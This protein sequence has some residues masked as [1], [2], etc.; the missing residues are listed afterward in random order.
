M[1]LATATTINSIT[2]GDARA[3]ILQPLIVRFMHVEALTR[4]RG[5]TWSEPFFRLTP[6][7][8]PH[9]RDHFLAWLSESDF[10]KLRSPIAQ[11]AKRWSADLAVP[12]SIPARGGNLVSRKRWTTFA[13]LF[14]SYQDD[15]RLIMKG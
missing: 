12:S 5:Y 11:W 7:L 8:H 1:Y 3:F 2:G 9:H 6:L 4:P 10:R 13:T 15:E 14:Q